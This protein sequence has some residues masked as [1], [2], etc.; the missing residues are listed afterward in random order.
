MTRDQKHLILSDGTSTLRFLDPG[1]F[2]ETGRIS[3]TDDRGEPLI[4]LNELE[5][6]RGQI[7]ANIWHTDRIVRISPRTGKVLGWIDLSGLMDNSQLADPDAVLNGIAYDSKRDRLFVTGKLWPTLF[8]I[9]IVHQAKG[10][11]GKARKPTADAA[12]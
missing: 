10:E 9:K 1:T 11:S 5:F 12:H 4:N 7:Y 8:E 3:V 6:I 2:R